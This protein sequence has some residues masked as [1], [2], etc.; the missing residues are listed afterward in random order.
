MR[1]FRVGAFE[2]VASNL[3]CPH[4]APAPKELDV[5][6][7]P[8]LNGKYHARVCVDSFDLSVDVDVT[9]IGVIDGGNAQK[10]IPVK[11]AW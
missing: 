8:I 1:D 5:V 2:M 10:L 7:K 11:T 9:R 3:L 4:D 6:A